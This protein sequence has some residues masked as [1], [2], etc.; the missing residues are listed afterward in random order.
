MADAVVDD[1]DLPEA[2]DWADEA[3]IPSWAEPDLSK[4][5][6]TAGKSDKPKPKGKSKE[7]CCHE[8]PDSKSDKGAGEAKPPAVPVRKD[9]EKSGE[10]PERVGMEAFREGCRNASI[11]PGKPLYMVLATTYRSV[12]DLK[13]EMRAFGKGAARGLTPEGEADLIQRIAR[14]AELSMRESVAKHRIRLGLWTSLAA[15]GALVT[16]LV[17]GALGGYWFGWTQGRDAVQTAAA[18][19]SVAFSHGKPGA[20]AAAELLRYNDVSQMLKACTGEAVFVSN[21]RKACAGAFWLEPA[22]AAAAATK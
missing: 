16:A 21:G 13:D 5:G 2:P 12:L 7:K 14:Q 10:V 15:G 22:P 4:V 11:E 6:G 8:Q 19:V 3:D 9:A 18:E 20:L 17:G 1:E